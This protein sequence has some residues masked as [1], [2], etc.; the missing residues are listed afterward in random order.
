MAAEIPHG[1]RHHTAQPSLTANFKPE[2]W[3]FI[4]CIR[5]I[6]SAC[7]AAS[8]IPSARSSSHSR[9]GEGPSIEIEYAGLQGQRGR[10]QHRCTSTAA[11][12]A[13]LNHA[14]LLLKLPQLHPLGSFS[15]E[16]TPSRSAPRE[17]HGGKSKT[18]HARRVKGW[19]NLLKYN[20]SKQINYDSRAMAHDI[21]Q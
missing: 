6:Q 13:G 12:R 15:D 18:R 1:V 20:K 21:D 4:T 3:T 2:L 9:H 11:G 14:P 10:H 17:T 16:R 7:A 8:C 19:L 5:L